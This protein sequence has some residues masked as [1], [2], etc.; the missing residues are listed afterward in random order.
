MSFLEQPNTPKITTENFA[1]IGTRNLNDDGLQAIK[2]V[3]KKTF[4]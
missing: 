1:G 4:E 2:N 3:Y